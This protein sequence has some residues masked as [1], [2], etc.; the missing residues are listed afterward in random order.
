MRPQGKIE[1]LLSLF[2]VIFQLGIRLALQLS[3]MR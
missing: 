2:K 1:Q 3:Y